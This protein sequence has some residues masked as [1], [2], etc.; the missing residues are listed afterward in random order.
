MFKLKSFTC[1]E[2]ESFKPL[3][4]SNI[5]ENIGVKTSFETPKILNKLDNF[6]KIHKLLNIDIITEKKYNES[7]NSHN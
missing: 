6:S 3:V 7:T 2:E 5:P 1:K 4:T